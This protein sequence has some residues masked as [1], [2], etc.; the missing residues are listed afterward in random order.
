MRGAAVVVLGLCMGG[1]AASSGDAAKSPADALRPDQLVHLATAAEESGDFG[2]AA[3]LY[4]R[5]I[6]ANPKDPALRVGQ[7]R[8]LLF[9]GSSAQAEAALHEAVALDPKRAD[10]HFL[11]GQ[12]AL[13]QHDANA[14]LPEFQAVLDVEPKNLKAMNDK[15]IALD[16]LGRS[17]EAQAIYRDALKVSPDDP[18]TRNNLGLSLTLSGNYAEATAVLQ[19]LVM[20]PGATPKMRQNLALALGLEGSG[21]EAAKVDHADLD[22]ASTEANLRYFSAVRQ[23]MKEATPDTTAPDPGK[24]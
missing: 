14:A 11:L 18:T 15:G 16:F 6:A 3:N 21:D 8:D 5:A 20:E 12:I 22:D 24:S 19:K 13:G 1:C 7:A 2:S 23:L 17:A 9:G 4:G 10:A